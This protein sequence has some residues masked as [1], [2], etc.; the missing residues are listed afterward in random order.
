M[1]EVLKF[2]ANWC[3][4]CRVLANNLKG[5]EGITSINIDTDIDLARE[6]NVRSVPVLVFKVDDKE[7]HREVGIISKEKY[8]SLITELETD[9]RW[10]EK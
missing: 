10:S 9:I 7:I 2:S 3:G 6:N 5:V 1:I 4:P 8:Q